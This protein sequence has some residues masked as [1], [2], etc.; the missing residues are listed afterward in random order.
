MKFFINC[1]E[2]E[3]F[4][5]LGKDELLEITNMLVDE[6]NKRLAKTNIV[7][8]LTASAKELILKSFGYFSV[9]SR[10][11]PILKQFELNE[12][13]KEERL[14][15][16]PY[17]LTDE[18]FLQYDKCRQIYVQNRQTY[19]KICKQEKGKNRPLSDEVVAFRKENQA[20]LEKLHSYPCDTCNRYKKHAKNIEVLG[21][22]DVR[23]ARLEKELGNF[24]KTQQG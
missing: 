23:Q 5:P 19:K 21:R 24:V 12:K 1:D 3:I 22:L 4:D 8:E 16:C 11:Q 20:M 6:L 10:M 7:L 15:E 14:F 17:K 13:E 18:E 9:G 2:I